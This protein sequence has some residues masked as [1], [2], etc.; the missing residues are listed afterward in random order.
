MTANA[1]IQVAH[2]D[3]AVIVPLAAFSY[4]PPSGSVTRTKR[5][6]TTP[7]GA[8]QAQRAGAASGNASPWGKTS[9]GS[10]GA[11]SAG[12]TGRI[13]VQRGGALVPVRVT[14]GLVADTQ[15]SVTPLRGTLTANDAVVVADSSSAAGAK[16]S[17][18]VNPLAG[19]N[20]GAPG[21]R[22]GP[23]GGG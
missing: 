23:T 1:T 18:T 12:G 2:V 22:R 10:S 20:Q 15:A 8:N 16:T 6:T 14:I 5:S 9:G 7:A 3:N 17:S 21:G 11:V 4:N 13:F 19:G